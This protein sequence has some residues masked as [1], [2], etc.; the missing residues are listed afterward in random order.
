MRRRR[1]RWRKNAE[2]VKD[3][4]EMVEE[5]DIEDEKMEEEVRI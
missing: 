3:E 5:V 4:K 2:A 1:K